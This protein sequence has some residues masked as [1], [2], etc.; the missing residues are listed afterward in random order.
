MGYDEFYAAIAAGADTR[1]SQINA[2]EYLTYF[3][4]FLAQGKDIFHVC[5]STGLSGT[6]N[7]A[8][9]AA[10]TA[11]ERYPDRKV[12]VVD[13]LAASSGFG[14][15]MDRLADLRD[16]GMTLEELEVWFAENRSKLHHW[17][18]TTDLSTFIRGGRVSKTSGFVGTLL[19]ICAVV[20]LLLGIVNS[21]TEPVI[22][23][24]QEEK[25]A[26]A[27]AQVLAA[28]DYRAKAVS[29]ENVFFRAV[30]FSYVCQFFP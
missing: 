18:F 26:A 28:D 9:I 15:L 19:G 4:S 10:E 29:H 2:E 13:S 7:S 27:M 6:F 24:M 23:K 8:R 21:L 14:L 30:Y 16:T 22:R 17:F 11:A 12:V 25:T 20:A 3:E 5:L 1:T